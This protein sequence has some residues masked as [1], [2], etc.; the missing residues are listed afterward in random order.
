M[1]S[2]SLG[3]CALLFPILPSLSEAA[4]NLCEGLVQDK[5]SRPV[6]SLA[7]PAKRAA[8]VDPAFGT[9]I[10][11]ITA[12]PTGNENAV[13]K[14]MYSTMQAWNA[15]ESLMILWQRG[16]GH[17]LYDGKNYNF[18]QQLAIAPTDLEQVLWDPQNP[19]IFYYPTNLNAIPNLMAHRVSTNTN[20]LV[21]TFQG[22]PTH[23]P[24][25][26][27][28]LL[29]LGSDPQYMSYGPE[30]VVGLKC[31]DTK[32]TYSISQNRV[33]AN[34][35]AEFQNALIPAPSGSLLYYEG[36]VLDAFANTLRKL[37]MAATHEHACIG[38]SASGNDT[39]N[40]VAFQDSIPGTLVSYTLN[41]GA[42]KVIIGP[43]TGWPYPP[44][45]THISAIATKNPGWA[46]VSIVGDPTHTG[47]LSQEVVLANTDS[48]QVCR[49]GHHR[50][51]AGEGRW[52]YWAEPHNVISPSG[53]RVLFGSDWGNGNS[54][55][56]YVIELPGYVSNRAPANV[57][58]FYLYDA[59]RGQDLLEIKNGIEINL[60][61]YDGRN[62][63][64]R[65]RVSP[66]NVSH[67]LF[68]V[69]G[70]K[71][72]MDS[73]APYIFDEAGNE[74]YP[75]RKEFIIGSNS[76]SAMALTDDLKA[77]GTSLA[78]NFTFV[79]R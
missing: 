15:D 43:S 66:A 56:T 55:D 53:T 74:A 70:T 9:T 62:L 40:A 41:T 52:G 42:R 60:K 35:S 6:T 51:W 26:W 79:S 3:L 28:Q 11:R 65:A 36:Y 20:F 38:R 46:A 14:P 63:D 77:D 75:N 59:D 8:V 39:Y 76:I 19:D 44:A 45:G 4:T 49:V 50:S 32:F 58:T 47:L 25:D 12:V 37:N 7:K 30:K 10:R 29:S 78:V 69:N 73:L 13:I 64:V 16:K 57:A 33:I 24:V 54:V 72:S 2:S 22:A 31:G 34:G 18:I 17:L 68:K 5:N 1:K 71:Y 61:P 23:C 21:K 67:M 48:R 27:G